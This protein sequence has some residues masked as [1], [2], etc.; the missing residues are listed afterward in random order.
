[1]IELTSRVYGI[2][3]IAEVFWNLHDQIETNVSKDRRSVRKFETE[4]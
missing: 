2:L 4:I 3:I 1:M